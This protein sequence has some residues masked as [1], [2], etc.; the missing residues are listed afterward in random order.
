MSEKICGKGR[1][2]LLGAAKEGIEVYKYLSKYT[3]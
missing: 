1:A 2:S 3:V